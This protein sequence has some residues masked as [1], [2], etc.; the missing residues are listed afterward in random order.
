MECWGRDKKN[1]GG[2]WREMVAGNLVMILALSMTAGCIQLSMTVGCI[3][4]YEEQTSS[5]DKTGKPTLPPKVGS[6][7]TDASGASTP[8]G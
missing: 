6:S 5:I 3:Q 4:P 7:G 8:S 1:G 2:G